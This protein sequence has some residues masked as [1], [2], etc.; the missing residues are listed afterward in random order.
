MYPGEHE[1]ILPPYTIVECVEVDPAKV[2]NGQAHAY[3][4]FQVSRDNKADEKRFQPFANLFVLTNYYQFLKQ[5]EVDERPDLQSVLDAVSPFTKDSDR[6][7]ASQWMLRVNDPN[8]KALDPSSLLA[9]FLFSDTEAGDIVGNFLRNAR[10]ILRKDSAEQRQLLPWTRAMLNYIEG[11]PKK[12]STI[13]YKLVRSRAW[14]GQMAESGEV[15][16]LSGEFWNAFGDGDALK[17]FGGQGFEA[18]VVAEVPAKC[19]W[20]ADVSPL[21]QFSNEAEYVVAPY[22]LATWTKTTDGSELG[23]AGVTVAVYIRLTDVKD[24]GAHILHG[25]SV[26]EG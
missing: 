12:P 26:V 8:L 20:A 23:V 15:F 9:G 24:P 10:E 4:R 5:S 2:I 13:V 7:K 22:A 17:F 21:T 19:P 18:V 1:V 14:L 11:Y 3:A 6:E 16:V 25:L